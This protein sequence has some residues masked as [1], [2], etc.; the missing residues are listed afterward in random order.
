MTQPLIKPARTGRQKSLPARKSATTIGFVNLGCSKNQVDSEVM[1]GTLVQDGFQLTGD[2]KKAE[3]VIINTCGF[4]EEAKQESINS[5][6][7]H[8]KLKQTGACRVL[9]A[10]GCLAQR[11]QGD[12]LKELPELD[13]VVGTGEFGKI[14]D[15]CRDLLAPKKR[16]QRLWISQP[17]YLYDELAPRLRLG[18]QH[19]A[20]VKIAEGCNRNCAFCAIPLMRGRQRS[21][22]VASIV[23]EAR[24]LAAEGVKEINLI[25]QDTINY[26]VDLGLRQGL[27]RLLRE[28]V[29]VK[30]LRWIRPFYLYP[31]QVTDELLDLYAGEEKITKYIDMP[32]QHINDRILKRM[33]R[34]GDRAAIETLVDRIRTRIPGVTF[35]TAF[36]VGFPGETDAAFDELR[37]YMTKTE[38]DRVAVFL[39]SD[40]E[41]TSAVDLDE[42][43]E[44]PVMDERR[45]E[46]LAIQEGIA[47]ARN[48]ARIGSTMTVL[49]EGP[50]EE[51]EWLLEGRHEG[52]APEIDGVVYI[53]DGSASAGDL[54]KVEITD[55]ATYDLVGHIVA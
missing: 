18:G 7:E 23:A 16:H 13:G 44:R 28:L 25:S 38:F 21:R 22:P 19:S 12:L 47:A 26:G 2:P 27:V 41:G 4:I 15:I 39:Y 51:T 55:A 42:K 53:N 49:V 45:N 8:G 9:I 54:V 36:I 24:R 30:D 5:I 6:L 46:L 20:Y 29:K 35:R 14:A 11:Y 43:V 40:E 33:H 37:S 17:P 31:Q 3:V 50:S 32:L 48:R 10:A 52:L 34:L 1:L